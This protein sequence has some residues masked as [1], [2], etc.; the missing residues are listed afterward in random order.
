MRNPKNTRSSVASRWLSAARA[1]TPA[2]PSV[3]RRCGMSQ[4]RPRSEVLLNSSY[5]VARSHS[6]VAMRVGGGNQS[7]LRIP[8]ATII[9]HPSSRSRGK[10]TASARP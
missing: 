1:A 5:L 3:A 4:G 9:S 10:A 7:G 2:T 8:A 6:A